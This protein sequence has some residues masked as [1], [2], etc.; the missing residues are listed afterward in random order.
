MPWPFRREESDPTEAFANQL[1][2]AHESWEERI[3][4]GSPSDQTRVVLL[5]ATAGATVAFGAHAA[6]LTEK[7][8]GSVQAGGPSSDRVVRFVQAL[9]DRRA[10]DAAY[11]VV[12]WALVSEYTAHFSP[13][14]HEHEIGKCEIVFGFQNL[15]EETAVAYGQPIGRGASEDEKIERMYDLMKA[16]LYGMISAALDEPVEPEDDAVNAHLDEWVEQFETGI[17]VGAERLE[18]LGME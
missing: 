12:A 1:F 2:A 8:E 17:D 16:S 11:R 10:I 4:A 13:A 6:M 18:Q 9:G 15:Y 3:E 7:V 14:D 5:S